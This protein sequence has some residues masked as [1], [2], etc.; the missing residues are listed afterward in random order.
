MRPYLPPRISSAVVDNTI[1]AGW[2][3]LT[4]FDFE[5]N[6]AAPGFGFGTE[7]NRFGL[8]GRRK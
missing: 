6:F 1:L 2:V 8:R 3:R 7:W 4:L 5:T